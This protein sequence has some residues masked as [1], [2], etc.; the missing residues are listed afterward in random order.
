MVDRTADWQA[1][2]DAACRSKQLDDDASKRV[3]AS[4]MLK[5]VKGSSQFR[6][7]ADQVQAS[8]A[9]LRAFVDENKRDYVAAAGRFTSQQKDRIEE[10]VLQV[11]SS[12]RARV[13]QLTNSIVAAQQQR[14][15]AGGP[16]VNEQT[17]AH[18]HGAVLV[19]VEMLHQTSAAFDRC[20]AVRGAQQAAED[21]RR[22]QRRAA[23]SFSAPARAAANGSSGGGG[24]DHEPGGSGGGGGGG[25]QQQQTFQDQETQQLL[26]DLMRGANQV[27]RVERTVRE[28]T[29]MQQMI[30]TAV[31]Q[32]AEQI[33]Q[34]YNVAVEATYHV[35]RGNDELRKTL[36][37]NSSS[38]LYLV[39]L[40][41]TASALM[42]LFD[43]INS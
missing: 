32:Q 14:G 16:A 39:V 3:K 10:E 23:P 28:I 25:S 27:E 5:P 17:V 42:L 31:M 43:W 15:P 34:L 13:E 26:E 6:Q 19:L 21:A 35:R 18:L 41:L 33:E 29:T 24:G 37:V 36:A 22:Q 8:I 9:G 38:T 1:A 4:L 20:R 40:L 12:C 7:A 11:V 2:V 30:S